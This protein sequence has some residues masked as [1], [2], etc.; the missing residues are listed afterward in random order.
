MDNVQSPFTCEGCVHAIV[1]TDQTGCKFNL[2][3]ALNAEKFDKYY[4]LDRTCLF[5]NKN[6]EE[7]DVKLGYLFILEDFKD[8]PILEANVQSIKDKNPIWIGVSTNDPSKTYQVAKILD[9]AKCEYEIIGNYAELDPIYKLDQFMKHYKNG[10][11]LVNIVGQ[12]FDPNVKD[13]LQKFIIEQNKKTAIIKTTSS[14]DD[15]EINGICYFNFIFK[16]LNGNKPEL[17]EED[18]AYYA[19]SFAHKVYEKDQNMIAT[20]SAL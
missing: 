12:D 9:I 3:E 5:K 19:K 14:P 7:V 8:L 1:D 2:L 6:P 11:T 20:W 16:Y 13:K 15:I 18:G 4:I 17:N 10:W